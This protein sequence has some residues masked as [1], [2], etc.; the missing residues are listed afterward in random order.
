MQNYAPHFRTKS[1]GDL[2]VLAVKSAFV[3]PFA[4]SAPSSLA[5][6]ATS[7]H[8][9][10]GGHTRAKCGTQRL[11][12]YL[13]VAFCVDSAPVSLTPACHFGGRLNLV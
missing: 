5:T 2:G 9:R 6:T 7:Q 3:F 4:V 11:L 8:R 1:L 12:L 13:H 10:R